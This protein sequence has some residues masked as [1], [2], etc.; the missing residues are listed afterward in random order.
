MRSLLFAGA[1]GFCLLCASVAHAD[2]TFT[3]NLTPTANDVYGGG[4]GSFSLNV[5]P[6]A[7]AGTTTYLAGGDPANIGD[8]IDSLAVSIDGQTFTLDDAQSE[9]MIQFASGTLTDLTYDGL[10]EG[11]FDIYAVDAGQ[12]GFSFLDVLNG[13]TETGTIDLTSP[14]SVTPEPSSLLL[15]ATGAVAAFGMSRRRLA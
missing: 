12:M 10:V 8:T 14:T 11:T 9:T 15:L 2:T 13:T 4:S 5:A 7:T 1:A 3:F 6:P